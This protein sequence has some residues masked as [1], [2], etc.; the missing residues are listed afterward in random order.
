M[1]CNHR[2]DIPFF[3]NEK[4]LT[5]YGAE[6]GVFR[7]EYSEVLLKSWCGQKLY[8]I[9]AWKHVD[10]AV[11]IS[12][13][14]DENHE[15]NYLETLTR[16][17]PYGSKVEILRGFSKDVSRNF[18]DEYFDFVYLD[19]GHTYRNVTTDIRSWYPKIKVNGYLMGHDYLDCTMFESN[20]KLSPTIFEVKSAVDAFALLSCCKVTIIPDEFFP[21]WYIKKM[22]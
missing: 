7:G 4:G 6:I 5:G 18:Q 19:A 9:D 14:S 3:L 16:V 2:N 12:N 1:V 10:G 22:E 11:D 21:S 17:A 8:L 20:K 15:L 13:Y